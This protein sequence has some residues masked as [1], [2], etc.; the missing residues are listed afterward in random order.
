MRESRWRFSVSVTTRP[1]R[2]EE[3]DGVHYIFTDRARFEDMV[4]EG[5]FL[6]WAEYGG[7]LYG[8]PRRAVEAARA[9]GCDVALD[10]ELDGAT[11]VAKLF[12]D[13]ILVWVQPPSFEDLERRLR[14]RNDTADA[15]IERRLDR[16][17]RDLELAPALFAHIIVNDDVERAVQELVEV[18]DSTAGWSTVEPR[19]PC[20]PVHPGAPGRSP[21]TEEP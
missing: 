18:V 17:R 1:P 8:T 19:V 5:E 3:I 11:Q 16:A 4:G 6:E 2:P 12:P 14:L 10:I 20:R 15:D 7:H 9:A 21:T 13:A